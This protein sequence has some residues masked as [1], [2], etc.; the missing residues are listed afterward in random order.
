MRIWLNILSGVDAQGLENGLVGDVVG[1]S[2]LF[3]REDDLGSLVADDEQSSVLQAVSPG[4]SAQHPDHGGVEARP[5][6]L[7]AEQAQKTG[8]VVH[9][10]ETKNL[11]GC[12]TH[13]DVKVTGEETAFDEVI[14]AGVIASDADQ[15]DVGLVELGLNL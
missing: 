7:G 12:L 5:K 3:V 1:G 13:V 2:V 10:V 11:V 8:G 15:P 4:V 9:P 6:R 14:G